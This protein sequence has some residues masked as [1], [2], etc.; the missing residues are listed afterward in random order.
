MKFKSIYYNMC[1]EK[2][3]LKGAGNMRKDKMIFAIP[4]YVEKTLT[5]LEAAGHQAYC[6]GGCVRDSLL[7][8]EP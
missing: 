3:Q 4:A 8:Q 5:A 2:L 6:V 1:M 7:G